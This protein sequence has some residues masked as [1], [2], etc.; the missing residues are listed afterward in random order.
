MSAHKKGIIAII[1]AH[2]IWG[3]SFPIY[4]WA[5]GDVPPYTFV[6]FRFFFAAYLFLPFVYKDLAIP[7]KDWKDFLILSLTGVTFSISFLF[8]GLSY[9]SSLNAPLVLSAGPVFILLYLMLTHQKVS[10]KAM[11]GTGIGLFGVLFIVLKPIFEEGFDGS[12]LGNIFLLLASLCGLWY[13]IIIKRI[14]PRY[15]PLIINFWTFVIGSLPLF[16][17]VLYELSSHTLSSIFTLSGTIGLVYGCVLASALAHLFN[18]FAVKNMQTS[19]I[20]VFGYMDPIATAV[21]AIPLLGEQITL[22]YL[23]GAGLIL[24]GIYVTEGRI[25]WHPLHLWKN[26]HEQ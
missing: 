3:A 16:P 25:H 21:I 15:S 6:F 1:L 26:N 9:T 5:L 2:I 22:T 24:L 10:R 19:E 11:I 4:K 8:L 14:L 20:G 18:A 7:R 13:L 23:T 17:L 12:L